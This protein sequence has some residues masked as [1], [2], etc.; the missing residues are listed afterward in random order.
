MCLDYGG[1]AWHTAVT[2]L[3]RIVVKNLMELRGFGKV[4]VDK[5]AKPPA[6]VC[7][8]IAA[9]RRVEPC[10]LPPAIPFLALPPRGNV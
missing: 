3:Q 6:D 9:V 2:E 8:N 5:R 4:L 7:G 10:Y 1:D